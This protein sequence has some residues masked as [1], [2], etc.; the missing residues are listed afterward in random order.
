[1]SE[2][3]MNQDRSLST[4]FNAILSSNIFRVLIILSAF[5]LYY[6][7][8]S[9][10]VEPF[11]TE[12]IAGSVRA[13]AIEPVNVL[14][15][16]YDI[17]ASSKQYDLS[18]YNPRSTTISR[19]KFFTID[20]RVVALNKFLYD[21]HSPMTNNAETFIKEADKYGL[22]WRLLPSISGVESAFGNLI[23]AGTHNGWGWRGI[24]GN[25]AGWSIF[26]S[27]DDAIIH[28][29]QRLALGYGTDL[30]PYDIE[31]TYC[32]PCAANPAHAWANGVQRFM[33]QLQY[34]LDNLESM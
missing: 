21:Y 20:P 29:T 27:W 33:I 10:K 28:I 18:T 12:Q 1:M 22:D 5:I 13:S 17:F 11:F 30:T 23:P 31:P 7:I 2:V 14:S 25:D 4:V 6:A 8:V 34:Y 19:T 32:P 24:N 3:S 15:P 26:A 16:V 9:P